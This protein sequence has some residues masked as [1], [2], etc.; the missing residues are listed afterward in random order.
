MSLLFK[1]F[2]DSSKITGMFCSDTKRTRWLGRFRT[3]WIYGIGEWNVAGDWLA[4]AHGV[5]HLSQESRRGTFSGP[6]QTDPAGS[7][8]RGRRLCCSQ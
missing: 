4:P 5:G 8:T 7:Q 2:K 3:L 6:S 1:P